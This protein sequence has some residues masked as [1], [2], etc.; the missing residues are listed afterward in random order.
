MARRDE[1]RPFVVHVLMAT[2]QCDERPEE[3][4]KGQRPLR[5]SD[6]STHQMKEVNENQKRK[7]W[8]QACPMP[9]GQQKGAP[10]HH[11]Y[12]GIKPK[13]PPTPRGQ[14]MAALTALRRRPKSTTRHQLHPSSAP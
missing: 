11:P 10:L 1:Q 7:R 4:F 9:A 3:V 14:M 8:R 2:G 12:P 13:R 5:Q 6:L